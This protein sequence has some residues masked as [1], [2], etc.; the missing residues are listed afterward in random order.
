MPCPTIIPVT[1]AMTPDE[2]EALIQA[3]LTNIENARR[4]FAEVSADFA[5][6]AYRQ[7]WEKGNLDAEEWQGLANLQIRLWVAMRALYLGG[8]EEVAAGLADFDAVTPEPSQT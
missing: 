2:R 1:T 8:F 6:N 3:A 4:I 5:A 7:D